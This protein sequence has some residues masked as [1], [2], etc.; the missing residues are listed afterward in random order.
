MAGRHIPE[1]GPG[2]VPQLPRLR[3]RSATP[4]PKPGKYPMKRDQVIPV[5]KEEL[6]VGKRPSERRYRIRTSV[7]GRRTRPEAD[8]P[9]GGS[10]SAPLLTLLKPSIVAAYTA[11]GFWGEETIYHLAA[12]DPTTQPQRA[13]ISPNAPALRRSAR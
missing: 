10:L 9:R 13:R 5:V 12:P 11:A 3:L 7:A 2:S 8:R 6:A 1:V 4:L